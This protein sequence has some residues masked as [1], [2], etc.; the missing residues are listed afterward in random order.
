MRLVPVIMFALFL[1]ANPASA[2]QEYVY[3]D[4]GVAIQFPARPQASKSTFDSAFAK[5]LPS[6]VY[7]A[8]HDHVLYKLT[9]VDLASRP[10]KTAAR[11]RAPHCRIE[12]LDGSEAFFGCEG[13]KQFF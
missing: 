10:D 3:L 7:S 5:G 13:E 9:V 8:E 2:W 4:Q 6:M 12:R 11:R 1:A